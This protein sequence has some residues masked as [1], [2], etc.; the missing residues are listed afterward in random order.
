MVVPSKLMNISL[1]GGPQFTAG[2]LLD[3]SL[4]RSCQSFL[5]RRPL[6]FGG[7]SLLHTVY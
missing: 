3:S 1:R 4:A 7:P 2:D 5:K 6:L